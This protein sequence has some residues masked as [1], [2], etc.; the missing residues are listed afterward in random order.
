MNRPRRLLRRGAPLRTG[1]ANLLR[2]KFAAMKLSGDEAERRTAEHLARL[3]FDL[4]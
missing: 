4:V 3:G 2:S 1:S